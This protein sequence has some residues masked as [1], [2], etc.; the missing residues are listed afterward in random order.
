MSASRPGPGPRFDIARLLAGV[1]GALLFSLL[2]ACAARRPPAVEPQSAGER[3]AEFRT[4]R[5]TQK[6]ALAS[7]EVLARFEGVE[8]D[9]YLLGPGD[10]IHVDVWGRPEMSGDRVIGPDGRVTLPVV[11]AVAVADLSSEAA[12]A[13][14]SRAV[15]AAYFDAAVTVA[16]NEYAANRVMILGRVSNPGSL[17]FDTRP[18]LLDVITRAGALPV[19][20]IG[21]DKAALTRCAVFRGRDRV[22]WID[23][24]ALLT[25]GNLGLNI[26]LKRDDVVYIPDANDQLVYVLGYVGSPG[27]YTLTPDMSLMDAL[28]QAGGPT[29]DAAMGNLKLVRAGMGIETGVDLGEILDADPRSNFAL[30]EGDIL[31]VPPNWLTSVGY[32]LQKV[33]P[34]TNMAMFGAAVVK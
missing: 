4:S 5:K 29:P 7:A 26:R 30:E 24:K 18:R 1:A 27:A 14:M 10:K 31:Y 32:V 34:A 33:S 3:A 13:A 11:G 23:L 2:P 28:A 15:R 16:I 21:A 19:G 20:G 22:V 17:H 25:G 8:E 12:A 6:S 9:V